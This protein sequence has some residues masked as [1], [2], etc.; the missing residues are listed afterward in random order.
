MTRLNPEFVAAVE[1]KIRLCS[2]VASSPF[3]ERTEIEVFRRLARMNF[4]DASTATKQIPPRAAG[5]L[6]SVEVSRPR[7]TRPAV[8]VAASAK[9][10]GSE[11][12]CHD[13]PRLID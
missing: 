6:D 7:K 11:I 9:F 2:H 3:D 8:A 5:Q 1:T 4:L 13:S 10:V 12:G